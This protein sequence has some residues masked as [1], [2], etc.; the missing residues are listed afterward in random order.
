MSRI[1]VNRRTDR[2]HPNAV[3]IKDCLCIAFLLLAVVSG[4][5]AWVPSVP[6]EPVYDGKPL[7][8]WLGRIL[9][10]TH[11]ISH[12]TLAGLSVPPN[13]AEP[14]PD[15]WMTQMLGRPDSAAVAWLARALKRDSWLGAAWYRRWLWPKLPASMQGRLPPPSAGR[16]VVRQGAAR[17]LG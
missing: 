8:Y 12:H 6:P 9:G 17:L 15:E 5:W 16:A 2:W 11:A 14:P 10:S 1:L 13:P 3:P 7:P 4:L